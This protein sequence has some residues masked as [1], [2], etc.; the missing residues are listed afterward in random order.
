MARVKELYDAV[1]ICRS[2]WDLRPAEEV[3]VRDGLVAAGYA[4]P[5]AVAWRKLPYRCSEAFR[6][7]GP[8][9]RSHRQVLKRI[10]HALRDYGPGWE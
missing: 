10:R 4:D 5:F 8:R 6:F 3:A 7:R 1:K 9:F 2:R